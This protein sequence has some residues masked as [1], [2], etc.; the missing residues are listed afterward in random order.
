[1]SWVKEGKEGL[2]DSTGKMI[3]PAEYKDVGEFY[4]GIAKVEKTSGMYRVINT[5]GKFMLPAD[6]KEISFLYSSEGF[7][8]KKDGKYGV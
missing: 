5:K 8:A 4:D 7:Y 2:I 3:L 1:M 6:Y